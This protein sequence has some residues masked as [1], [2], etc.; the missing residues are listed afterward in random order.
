M[1][2]SPKGTAQRMTLALEALLAILRTDPRVQ[3]VY[4]AWLQSP[5]GDEASGR[6]A[7]DAVIAEM[8]LPY[9]WLTPPLIRDFLAS[10]LNRHVQVT[11]D[12]DE[13]PGRLSKNDGRHI[14]RDVE[15]Y[16]R[17][18]IKQPPDSISQLAREYA[19]VAGRDT[20]AH[21]VI[22]NGIARAKD[23]LARFGTSDED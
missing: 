13:L 19:V 7:V 12:L 11:V 22:R 9:P 4:D 5:P 20:K 6:R 17:A 8:H 23:L 3:R 21:S 16:Y 2:P 15:W 14:R 18:E 10:A 1:E